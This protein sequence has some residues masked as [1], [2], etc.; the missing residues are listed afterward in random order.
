MRPGLKL[1]KAELGHIDLGP[2]F[3]GKNARPRFLPCRPYVTY[4][5]NLNF[6]IFFPL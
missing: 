3:I 2:G 1:L 5:A 6:S 4:A